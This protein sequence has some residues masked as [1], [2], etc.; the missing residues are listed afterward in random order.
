[1]KT[2]LLEALAAVLSN[3]EVTVFNY[4]LELHKRMGR[5]LVAIRTLSQS[6]HSQSGAL[7]LKK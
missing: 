1:M 3:K 6:S 2:T 4:V 7:V 5:L